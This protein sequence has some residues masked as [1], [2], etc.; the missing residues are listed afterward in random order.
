MA[1]KDQIL[2]STTTKSRVNGTFQLDRTKVPNDGTIKGFEKVTEY[3]EVRKR[4][5]NK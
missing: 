2:V 1:T 3:Y 4:L 5:K